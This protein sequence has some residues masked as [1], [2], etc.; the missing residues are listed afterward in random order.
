MWQA[1]A[2]G[3]RKGALAAIPDRVVDELIVHGT[4]DECRAKV[5]AYA[6]AGVQVP[7]MALLPTP[8]DVLTQVRALGIQARGIQALGR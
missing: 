7:V 5:Q 4:P 3:D 2:A 1:W 6:D 8:G